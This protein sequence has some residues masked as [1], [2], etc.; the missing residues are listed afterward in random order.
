[1]GNPLKLYILIAKFV[2]F[3]ADQSN[4]IFVAY[5]YY[6]SLACFIVLAFEHDPIPPSNNDRSSFD[7]V[8]PIS[9]SL[10][11]HLS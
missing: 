3:R 1:M 11:F 4:I 9:E 6:T 7:C 5:G 2:Q 8:L 10:F